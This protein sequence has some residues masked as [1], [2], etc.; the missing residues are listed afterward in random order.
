MD[1]INS[2]RDME[3]QGE[4]ISFLDLDSLADLFVGA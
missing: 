1:L 2:T 4:G 3:F